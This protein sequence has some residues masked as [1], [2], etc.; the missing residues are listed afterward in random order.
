MLKAR[1]ISAAVMVPLVVCGVLYLPSS[2]FAIA[3]AVILLAGLWEWSS[4]IGMNALA[5]RMA[6]LVAVAVLM[7]LFWS[8]D[9]ASII[10]TI[11]AAAFLWWLWALYWLSRPG[12]M[13][14][15]P[16][17][18]YAIKSIAGLMVITPAWAALVVLH[19]GG[20]TGPMLVLL[21]MLIIW[22]ADSCAFFAGRRWGRTKLAPV[23]S[24]GKTWQGVYGGM[25]GAL[26]LALIVWGL[27]S[28]SVSG[29]AAFLLVAILAVMFSVV[30]D[31]LESLMKRQ[32]GVKDSGNIIPGHGGILDRI[33]SL[34]AAAPIFLLCFRWL[35]VQP[36]Y[37]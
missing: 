20:E 5:V 31:L 16:R 22:I 26:L 33:D 30:G 14:G 1:L 32:R 13:A 19:T 36:V 9:L 4:L 18:E 10:D 2:G 15:R 24:P 34:T 29:T 17:L 23:I 7:W 27:Y 35:K 25:A 3:L 21:L 11:L 8:G 37:V 12:L 6:Y 28:R